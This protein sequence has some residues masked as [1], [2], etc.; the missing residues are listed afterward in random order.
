MLYLNLLALIESGDKKIG[1]EVWVVD[2]RHDDILN[3]PI[4][5]VPPTK[6]G[7]F[8]ADSL[9]PKKKVYYASY[10]FRVTGKNGNPLAAVIAPYDNTG[11]RGYTGISLNIFLTEREAKNFYITQC[12]K[13]IVAA[14]VAAEK[15]ASQF[16]GIVE[17]MNRKIS[18]NR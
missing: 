17:D 8:G 18:H 11:F 12:E 13:I 5:N 4:R 6:V 2:V 15:W 9:N 14:Q 3:K 16:A 10:H 1:D 7:I